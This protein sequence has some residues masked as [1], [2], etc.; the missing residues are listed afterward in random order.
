MKKISGVGPFIEARLNG[1]NIYTFQ[2]ISKMTEQIEDDVNEAIEYFPGRVRRDE[3][4]AQCK[5][6][7][8][9][10]SKKAPAKKAPAKKKKK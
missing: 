1:I 7:V 10:T 9:K 5:Q 4:V 2:Q 8:A 6:F 3:W